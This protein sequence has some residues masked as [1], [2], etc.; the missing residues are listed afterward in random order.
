MKTEYKITVGEQ[1][2]EVGHV[3]RRAYK[4]DL[5]AIEAA[6]RMVRPY[7]GDG[8]YKVEDGPRLVARG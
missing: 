5:H 4:G 2:N 7:K 8:W 1:G 3:T 6:R